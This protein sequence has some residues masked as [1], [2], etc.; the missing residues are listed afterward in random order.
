[1]VPKGPFFLPFWRLPH[2]FCRFWTFLSTVRSS[3]PQSLL[4]ALSAGF[5]RTAAC[6]KTRNCQS[7]L[8]CC[9]AQASVRLMSCREV[10]S[11][12]AARCKLVSALPV[13]RLAASS[14]SS[15]QLSST[16]CIQKSY[17]PTTPHKQ[18][19]GEPTSSS[20]RLQQTSRDCKQG[21]SDKAEGR[22][23][24]PPSQV[25]QKSPEEITPEQEGPALRVKAD[26]G[27]HVDEHG[28]NVDK[29]RRGSAHTQREAT[30]KR[31]SPTRRQPR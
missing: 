25:G 6:T 18:I 4:P 13:E 26:R 24:Y 23:H 7:A 28:G 22:E 14:H 29:L 20:F 10:P 17:P 21:K 15:I 19:R 31:T 5:D 3:K 9:R 2:P 30:D 12:E 11:A 8:K 27:G 16:T 1:M